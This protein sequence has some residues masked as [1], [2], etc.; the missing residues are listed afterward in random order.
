MSSSTLAHDLV[1]SDGS[2]TLHDDK[3]ELAGLTLA[4]TAEESRIRDDQETIL[5]K[6]AKAQKKKVNLTHELCKHRLTLLSDA[7]NHYFPLIFQ[8]KKVS[9]DTERQLLKEEIHSNSGPSLREVELDRINSLL[10]EQDLTV[11][12]VAS[13]GHCLYRC[14]NKFIML[15]IETSTL[16]WRLLTADYIL[17]FETVLPT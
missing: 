11:K 9:K 7:I 8:D 16:P 14:T 1:A 15:I 6:K 3:V 5:A 12:L 10:L 17:A 13:D 2:S 4:D